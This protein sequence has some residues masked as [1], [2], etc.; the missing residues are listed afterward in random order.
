MPFAGRG[1]SAVRAVL[2]AVRPDLQRLRAGVVWTELRIYGVGSPGR[3]L[4]GGLLYEV[5]R[6]GQGEEDAVPDDACAGGADSAA[7]EAGLHPVCLQAGGQGGAGGGQDDWGLHAADTGGV[8]GVPPW[9]RGHF[10][11]GR[12]NQ[13]RHAAQ[14]ADAAGGGQPEERFD[15]LSGPWFEDAAD[16]RHRIL[17]PSGGG[18]GHAGAAEGQI[19][20][21]HIG[22]GP[23]PGEADQRVLWHHPL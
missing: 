6:V 21:D 9:I 3:F 10:R 2:C 14:R 11:A 5:H 19:C 23:A 13:G 7:G 16:F 15:R 22:Q 20:P 17:K 18:A 8:G 4:G 1:L 12:G